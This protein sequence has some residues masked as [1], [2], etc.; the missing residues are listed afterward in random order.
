MITCGK[1]REKSERRKR[2]LPSFA[3]GL[4][5]RRGGVRRGRRVA[6]VIS[7]VGA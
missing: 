4:P 3:K 2:V 5:A 7:V 1:K 6:E